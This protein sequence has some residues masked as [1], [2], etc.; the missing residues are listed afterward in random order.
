MVC[1]SGKDR[2]ERP[3]GRARSRH[4]T[5]VVCARLLEET[6]VGGGGA[7]ARELLH[8]LGYM[9]GVPQ[10]SENARFERQYGPPARM[11]G[12]ARMII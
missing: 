6:R 1:A 5:R 3:V 2:R 12:A 10:G 11:H 8:K 4:P 7:P 9:G